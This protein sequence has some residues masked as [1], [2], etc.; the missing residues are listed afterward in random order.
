MAARNCGSMFKRCSFIIHCRFF[1][2]SLMGANARASR[3]LLEL[4]LQEMY[5]DRR[6][7]TLE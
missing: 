4:L 7:R 6:E 2:L 5:P 1:T 3:F